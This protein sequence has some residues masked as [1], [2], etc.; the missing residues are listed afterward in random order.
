M[1]TLS[2]HRLRRPG[3]LFFTAIILVLFSA[4]LTSGL[5]QEFQGLMRF[6]DVHEN[7]V[8]FVLGEDIWTAPLTGGAATRIT[9]HDGAERYPKFSPDGQWIAFTGEY[10]GNTDVY[11]MNRYGGQIT[12]V[13]F[14]PLDDV[15][16]G[17]HPVKNKILFSSNR[18][19]Y[20][21]FSRLFMIAP[22]GSGL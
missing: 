6:P 8:V 22:D 5:A 18:S 12:R 13:T 15:V 3:L 20:N 1:N 9:F 17:W 4:P 10:D 19:S 21:R 11:V 2:N 14:H 16:V 7:T